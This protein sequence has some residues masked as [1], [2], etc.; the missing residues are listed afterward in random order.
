MLAGIGAFFGQFQQRSAELRARAVAARFYGFQ[1][2]ER[3]LALE[4]LNRRRAVPSIRPG[5]AVAD[6]AWDERRVKANHK[7]PCVACE[8]PFNHYGQLFYQECARGPWDA[9]KLC[10]GCM[11]AKVRTLCMDI[12]ARL[13]LY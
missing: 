9:D 7:K 3:A 2:H 4:L 8:E 12:A 10:E 1:P 5:V 6:E 13:R 11:G